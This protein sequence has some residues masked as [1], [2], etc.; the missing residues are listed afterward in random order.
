MRTVLTMRRFRFWPFNITMAGL[1][2]LSGPGIG[3]IV[4]L[5]CMP[6]VLVEVPPLI[7][8]PGHMGAAAIEA[9]GPNSPLEKY[10]SYRWVFT[11]NIG[12]GV[13]MK[14][15]NTLDDD[16]DVQAVWANFDMSEEDLAKYA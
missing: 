5:V 8:S 10:F 3:V 2:W 15:I 6:F 11:L 9:A 7:D 16:D 13:L 14:L 1:P 12:D 4:A